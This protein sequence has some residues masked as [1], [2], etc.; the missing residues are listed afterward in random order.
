MIFSDGKALKRRW[1][2]AVAV[3]VLALAASFGRAWAS[4]PDVAQ[5]WSVKR[6]AWCGGGCPS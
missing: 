4:G 6:V 3:A 2:L 1:V 5:H